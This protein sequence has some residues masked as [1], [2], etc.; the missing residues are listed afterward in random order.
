MCWCRYFKSGRLLGCALGRRDELF[1]EQLVGASRYTILLP[2]F[3]EV[4]VLLALA[5]FLSLVVAG[6]VVFFLPSMLPI[7][8][9]SGMFGT[10]VQ[11]SKHLLWSYSIMVFFIEILFVFLLAF[12]GTSF[13]FK[14][15]LTLLFHP[16]AS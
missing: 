8:S 11:T 1:V 12:L 13:A 14:D 15:Q 9:P 6:I 4:L 16:R 7:L 5:L 10:W 2:F 3:V